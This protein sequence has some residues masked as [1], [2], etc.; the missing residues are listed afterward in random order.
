[1]VT[2]SKGL[3]SPLRMLAR[4]DLKSFSSTLLVNDEQTF[5]ENCSAG[6]SDPR[7]EEE[8]ANGRDDSGADTRE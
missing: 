6:D 8:S 3:L 5:R 4:F 1:M 2:A 7:C